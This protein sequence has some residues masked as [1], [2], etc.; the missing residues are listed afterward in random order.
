MPDQMPDNLTPQDPLH[1]IRAFY[2]AFEQADQAAFAALCDLAIEWT[3]AENFIYSD[4]SPYVGIAAVL[5][6]IFRRIPGDWDKFSLL[7]MELLGGGDLVI[8]NGRFR[9]VFRANGAGI[10][11]Q[12]VQVFQMKDGKVA[13]VQVYTDT[14]QFKDTVSQ[15]RGAG[16]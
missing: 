10:D 13:K 4:R 7:P 5:D 8:A 9:G 2:D 3:S 12:M 1:T 14:A 16:A 6:L 11:A 15:I